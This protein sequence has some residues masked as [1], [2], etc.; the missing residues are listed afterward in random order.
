MDLTLEFLG[1]KDGVTI[2]RRGTDQYGGLNV[3]MATP[4]AQVITMITGASNAVPRRAWSDLSG[5]FA[6]SDAPSGLAIFQH[7][8]NPDYPGDWVQFPELSWCQPT[9][10]ASGRRFALERERPLILRFRL[11][12]HPGSRPEDDCAERVWDSFGG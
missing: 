5:R 4:K 6:G 12:I 9:F 3:R 1:L 8:Q 2:A 7:A 10:P 11:W